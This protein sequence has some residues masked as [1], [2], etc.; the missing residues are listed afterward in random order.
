[1]LPNRIYFE[2]NPWPEGHPINTFEWTANVKDGDVWFDFHLK[3]A[4]YYAE[5]DIDDDDDVDYE[6]DWKAPC[7]WGNYHAC[8]MSS[9]FWHEGGFKVCT[10]EEFT[11]EFLDGLEIEVDMHPENAEDWDDLAFHIYLLGHDAVAC[12]K[13][14]FIRQGDSERFSIN[15]A[16]RIAQA[17]VGDYEF[18]HRFA[19]TVENQPL[20]T[21]G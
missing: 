13:I 4:E 8:T 19:L 1:M 5:R 21:L 14:K 11:P 20:P 7:V 12:H 18:K 9:N 15:W 10:L 17:Y 3:S 16:G 6:S 2:D